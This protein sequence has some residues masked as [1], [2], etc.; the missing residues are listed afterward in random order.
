MCFSSQSAEQG[1]LKTELWQHRVYLE[2]HRTHAEGSGNS[3]VG[4]TSPW[5]PHPPITP[6]VQPPPPTGVG[7]VGGREGPADLVGSNGGHYL[8]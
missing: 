4:V 7:M 3:L 1:L 2:P 6:M 8:P 5:L